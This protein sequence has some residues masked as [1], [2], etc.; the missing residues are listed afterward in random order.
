MKQ[1]EKIIK[2]STQICYHS[3]IEVLTILKSN[4]C[5]ME[6]ETC[7]GQKVGDEMVVFYCQ[8]SLAFLIYKIFL[9]IGMGYKFNIVTV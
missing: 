6:S 2:K 7:F 1:K 5:L 9:N 8:T 4:C 3:K